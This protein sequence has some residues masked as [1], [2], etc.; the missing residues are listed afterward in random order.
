MNLLLIGCGNVGSILLEHWDGINRIDRIA[1]VQPSMQNAAQFAQNPNISFFNSLDAVPQ[2]FAEEITVLAVKP[3]NLSDIMPFLQ[4]RPNNIVVSLLAG[5][6]IQQISSKLTNTSRIIR[7]MPNIALI[8]GNSLNLAFG[9]Q[10]LNAAEIINLEKL[11]ATSGSLIWLEQENQID[12]LTPISGCGPAYFLLIAQILVAEA[13][14]QGIDANLARNIIRETFLGTASLVEIND[15]Y[16]HWIDAISS[17]GG[18]TEAALNVLR[19]N[20]QTVMPNALN[21]ALARIEELTRE[22]SR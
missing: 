4:Q 9:Q 6:K 10:N 22:N 11:F 14:N 16:A 18:L 19:P 2:N 20:L 12:T 1:V 13:I 8:T 5:I 7:I 3:Q 21:A 15:D 17:K